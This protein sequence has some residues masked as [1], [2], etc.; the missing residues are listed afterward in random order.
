MGD[1]GDNTKSQQAKTTWAE[2]LIAGGG[3]ETGGK[4]DSTKED[5]AGNVNVPG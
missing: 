4:A 1:N 5:N 2:M 3:E